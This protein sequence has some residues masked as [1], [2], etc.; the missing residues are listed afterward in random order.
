ML[1]TKK[2]NHFIIEI[3]KLRYYWVADGRWKYTTR[4]QEK[5]E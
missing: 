4:I 3:I 2:R 5:G 1:Q